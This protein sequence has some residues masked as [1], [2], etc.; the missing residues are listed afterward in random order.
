MAF[1][2]TIISY[3]QDLTVH[4]A[5][6]DVVEEK[7]QQHGQAQPTPTTPSPRNRN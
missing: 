1:A 3:Q 6:Q 5:F 7:P 2:A 4:A